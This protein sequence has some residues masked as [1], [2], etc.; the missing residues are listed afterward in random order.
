[1]AFLD[2]V[3]SKVAGNFCIR[4]R[5]LFVSTVIGFGLSL[6]LIGRLVF[7]GFSILDDHQIISWLGTSVRSR[8][9]STEIVHYGSGTRFRPVMF[10]TLIFE[11]WLF[12]SKAVLY[13][14]AQI[15]WFGVFLWSIAWACA[16]SIG[17]LA[18]LAVLFLVVNGTYWGNIWTH[19]LFAA[20]Q[21][22]SFGWASSSLAIAW[23]FPGS[24]RMPRRLDGAVLLVSMGT[25]ICIGS[26]ENFLPQ[27]GLNILLL[28]TG[29]R[30]G[31]IE[32]RTLAACLP[33]IFFSC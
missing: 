14:L 15:V 31:A 28:A 27:V 10:L 18:G 5:V 3:D 22:A 20:E 29:W 1:M 4:N 33:L 8:I 9:Y 32:R 26:K 13:H 12:G 21:M 19:S 23:L 17:I 25:L 7:S 30:K 2:G 6:A 11:S 16:R 24:S